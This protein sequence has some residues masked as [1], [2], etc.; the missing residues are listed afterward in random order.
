MKQHGDNDGG[1]LIL[2]TGEEDQ[3][4]AATPAQTKPAPAVIGAGKH[5]LRQFPGIQSYVRAETPAVHDLET[6]ALRLGCSAPEL[7]VVMST[8]GLFLLTHNDGSTATYLNLAIGGVSNHAIMAV[9]YPNGTPP[10]CEVFDAWRS[11]APKLTQM[12]QKFYRG[13]AVRMSRCIGGGEIR[14]EYL[15]PH[16]LREEAWK[17]VVEMPRHIYGYFRDAKGR[18]ALGWK[19]SCENLVIITGAADFEAIEWQRATHP[20]AEPLKKGGREF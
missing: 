11:K 17:P 10:S 14:Q 12:D 1:V 2:P 20:Q 4:A 8:Q 13:E 18:L 6:P 9:V 3:G 15:Y 19:G 7:H 16:E 5:Y